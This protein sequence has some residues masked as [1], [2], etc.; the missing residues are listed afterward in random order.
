MQASTVRDAITLTA[1]HKID[2]ETVLETSCQ[3][4][5]EYKRLPQ[6]V[7]YQGIVCGLTGWNSDKNYACYKSSAQIATKIQPR[8]TLQSLIDQ[9]QKPI[10]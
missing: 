2:G 7:S 10:G 3:D 6:V 4:F 5:E 8:M 9:S 1:I